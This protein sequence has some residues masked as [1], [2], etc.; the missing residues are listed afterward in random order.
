[1]YNAYY[2][3]QSIYGN[4]QFQ[5]TAVPSYN[6]L[7]QNNIPGKQEVVRVNGKNGAEAFQLPPNSSILLLDETAPIVWLK[8]TDGAGYPT[9]T[10]Y[11]INPH[12]TETIQQN[13]IDIKPLEQRISKL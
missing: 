7:Q 4:N 10:P 5:Q 2:P 6:Q 3:Y 9:I 13:E 12:Q 11:D 8:I 1:M